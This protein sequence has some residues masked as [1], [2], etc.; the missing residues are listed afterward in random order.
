MTNTL[1]SAKLFFKKHDI[2]YTTLPECQCA[3]NVTFI[4]LLFA[5]LCKLILSPQFSLR[6]RHIGPHHKG[7]HRVVVRHLCASV[8]RQLLF[9][10][11]SSNPVVW[12]QCFLSLCRFC[13]VEIACQ[14]TA[15][16]RTERLPM[17]MMYPRH[18]SLLSF[19]INSN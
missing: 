4:V 14:W 10:L 11:F 6:G 16:F 3:V 13:C 15:S 17:S 18:L 1:R 5:C 19:T 8:D 9:N 7:N 12:C 2:T